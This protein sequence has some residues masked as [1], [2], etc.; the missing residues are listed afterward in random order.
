MGVKAGRGSVNKVPFAAAVSLAERNRPRFMKLSMVSGFTADANGK[1]AKASL[2]SDCTV[3]SEGLGCFGP[4]TA[5]GCIHYPVVFGVLKPRDLPQFHWVNTVLGHLKTTL[6][7]SYH[8][9]KYR[10]HAAHYLLH[11]PTAS[12]ACSICINW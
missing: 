3:I 5:A 1:W 10:K 4:V 12:T 2:S 7:G 11:L 6:A 8:A 9:L